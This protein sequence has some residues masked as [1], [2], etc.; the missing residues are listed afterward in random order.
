MSPLHTSLGRYSLALA[1][2]LRSTSLHLLGGEAAHV[3][4]RG[5][6]A[7]LRETLSAAEAELLVFLLA[8]GVWALAA[9]A[10]ALAAIGL[11]GIFDSHIE[12]I[13]GVVGGS[14]RIGLAL[15]VKVLVNFM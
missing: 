2:P 14:G 6:I 1:G 4:A 8:L 10:A 13:I 11:A 3:T 12:E 5:R 7:A 9:C 15:C